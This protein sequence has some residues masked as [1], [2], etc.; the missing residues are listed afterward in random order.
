MTLVDTP[1]K[2]YITW[3]LFRRRCPHR[4]AIWEQL[5]QPGGGC[6][7]LHR[8]PGYCPRSHG[9]LLCVVHQTEKS[10][11]SVMSPAWE[12]SPSTKLPVKLHHLQR[13][14]I[15][16]HWVVRNNSQT[17]R[18]VILLS[19]FL[20]HTQHYN[21]V[22]INNFIINLNHIAESRWGHRIC[23]KIVYYN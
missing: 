18:T 5:Q 11:H 9:N 13:M 6:D 15:I 17:S 21:K 7:H 19:S 1:M 14:A 23:T 12:W 2:Q 3:Y 16:V 20:F 10:D 8:R 22:V 4:F